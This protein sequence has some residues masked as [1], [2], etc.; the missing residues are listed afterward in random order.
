MK[1]K[2]I[3][4]SLCL[5]ICIGLVGCTGGEQEKY[6]ENYEEGKD[7]QNFS[8]TREATATK[9]GF[10][11]IQED[12]IYFV[13]KKSGKAVPLCGKPNCKHT[14]Y[15]CNARFNAPLNIQAYDGSI[16]VVARGEKVGTESLYRIS[17]DGS[18]REEL[19]TLYTFETDDASCSL[20]FVIHRGFG[21]MVTNW[22]QKTRN[23]KEQTLYRV[24]LDSSDEKDEVA[25][26][27][28]YTPMIY[29]V[30]GYGN[31]I[32]FSTNRY[33]DKDEKN[34]EILNYKFDILKERVEKIDLPADMTLTA[35]KN[36]RYFC[37]KKGGQ[38][39]LSLDKDGKDEKR[40]FDWK[41]DNT[42]VYHDEQYLY[43]DNEVYLLMHDRPDTE[44]RVAIIDYDG[45]KVCEWKKS[46][47]DN[48]KIFWSD[49]ELLLLQNLENLDYQMLKLTDVSSL[50]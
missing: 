35:V 2:R 1:N 25:K 8:T 16:Y 39:I 23:E 12:S 9:N 19:K 50:Q 31:S 6:S 11:A 27:K 3:I 4:L 13:D 45:H 37:Y 48:R 32:Y 30:G 40:I 46:G 44:R 5:L 33:T 14:D 7:S 34:L 22:I 38:E 18:E 28:G 20:D 36:D 42:L 17:E 43:L 10:Y 24:S 49:S 26:I 29:I 15:S 21:Y 47:I 41:Y